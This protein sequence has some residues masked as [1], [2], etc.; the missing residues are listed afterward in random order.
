MRGGG[1]AGPCGSYRRGRPWWA[2]GRGRCPYL[3][4]YPTPA[5]R[6]RSPPCPAVPAYVYETGVLA[7]QAA[8][9][10]PD[11]QLLPAVVEVIRLSRWSSPVGGLATRTE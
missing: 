11:G 7:A 2:P 5:A 10:L 9:V 4:P 3:Y 6:P 1:V 8:S